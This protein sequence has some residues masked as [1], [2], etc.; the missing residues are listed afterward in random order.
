MPNK[1]MG[2]KSHKLY[3]KWLEAQSEPVPTASSGSPSRSLPI[4]KLYRYP[5]LLT[6][7]LGELMAFPFFFNKRSAKWGPYRAVAYPGGFSGCPETPPAMIFLFR[8][9]TP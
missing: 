1:S 8:G 7:K 6:T 2:G 3:A 5:L 9:V 4:D